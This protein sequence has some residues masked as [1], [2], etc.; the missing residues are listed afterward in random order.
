MVWGCFYDNTRGTFVPLIT[1]SVDQFIYQRVLSQV[2]APVY[3]HANRRCYNT[4]I[5]MQ[6]NAP[7]HKAAMPMMWLA[8]QEWETMEWPPY[9]PDL[10][11]IEHVW[12]R[13]KELLHQHYPEV[14]QMSG[15]PARVKAR[16]IEVL[17]QC[18]EKIEP[19][20]LESLWKSMPG[21]VQAVIEAG[22]WYTKY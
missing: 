6:D 3:E 8:A 14:A 9:S 1:K 17:P 19:G 5:F 4:A 7:V 22:G 20:F 21:R 13:L 16:L 12:R 10:N 15:G 2:A 18:W 11:P